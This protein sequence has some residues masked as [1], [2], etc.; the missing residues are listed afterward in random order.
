MTTQG[1]LPF[2]PARNAQLKTCATRCPNGPSEIKDMGRL[3]LINAAVCL[4]ALTAMAAQDPPPGE[5]AD[6]A[7]RLKYLVERLRSYALAPAEG[8]PFKLLETPLMRWQN[9]I[10]GADGGVFVWTHDGRPM[11]IARLG[12]RQPDA[13][14]PDAAFL[15]G[16]APWLPIP[17]PHHTPVE[18]LHPIR[19]GR[20]IP[21]T[22]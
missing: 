4:L 13:S 3:G 17:K 16:S 18:M 2:Q 20:D 5:D 12:S 8:A 9:A 6:R 11:A 7:V 21:R 14:G 1:R 10:S 15:Y 22:R 19:E